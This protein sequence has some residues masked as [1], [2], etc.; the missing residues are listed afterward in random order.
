MNFPSASPNENIDTDNSIKPMP[1]RC[2][3]RSSWW[4]ESLARRVIAAMAY[5]LVRASDNAIPAA[6]L[7]QYARRDTDGSKLPPERRRRQA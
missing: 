2:A 7:Q 5:Q 1:A 6:A 3:E 4:E